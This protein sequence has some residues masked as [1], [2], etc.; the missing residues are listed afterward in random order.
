MSS[1]QQK[2]TAMVY[3]A[4]AKQNSK[5]M[6]HETHKKEF[7]KTR[8]VCALRLTL[9]HVQRVEAKSLK[10]N[11]KF[12]NSLSPCDLIEWKRL[13][14]AITAAAAAAVIGA[15]A[16]AAPVAIIMETIRYYESPA[17]ITQIDWLANENVYVCVRNLWNK[18]LLTYFI[19]SIIR[20]PLHVCITNSIFNT[21]ESFAWQ[22]E[23]IVRLFCI[24]FLA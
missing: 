12:Q 22:W 10:V 7:W 1:K 20:L 2:V 18:H 14:R 19:I 21:F 9:T 5:Q 6:K 24:F 15:A 4:N 17:T 16:A 8:F 13:K 3:Q 11:R 23:S